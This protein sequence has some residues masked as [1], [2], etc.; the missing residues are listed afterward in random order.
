MFV[1]ELS[2]LKK[3]LE[4]LLD[5][6]FVHPSVLSWGAPVLLVTKKND[7]MRLCVN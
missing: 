6:K 7:N 2:E 1:L 5:K 4:D 3:Q